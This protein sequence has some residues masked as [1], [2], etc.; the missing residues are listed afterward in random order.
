[1]STQQQNLPG[2]D[3][4]SQDIGGNRTVDGPVASGAFASKLRSSKLLFK[5][6]AKM[7][8]LGLVRP[9]MVSWSP[10][11]MVLHDFLSNE[12]CD[13][14]IGL[15]KNKL[16][17]AMVL[18]EETGKSVSDYWRN[19]S[20]YFATDDEE[21]HPVV[22][23][24]L[25]RISYFAQLPPING[26]SLQI[27]RY[28]N[29]EYYKEHEDVLFGSGSLCKGQRAVTVLLYLTS[30]VVGG[31]TIF[32][33]G[34]GSGSCGGEMRDGLAVAPAKGK[35]TMFWN[36]QPNGDVDTQAIHAGCKVLAGEKWT[37]TKWI[38]TESLESSSLPE[39]EATPDTEEAPS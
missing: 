5:Q 23:P 38:C 17:P 15:A 27:L 28:R 22:Q 4:A 12:E 3:Q 39:D 29:G 16:E 31:E 13:H 11:V 33:K 14:L 30:G 26:E 1:M 32:I 21:Q 35:A 36:L 2:A 10:R 9:E 20:Y 24:I 19:S 34:A 18:D 37:A 25:Q 7:L 6:H 8:R